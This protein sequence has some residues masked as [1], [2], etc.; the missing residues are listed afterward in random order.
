MHHS[1]ALLNYIQL[2][3]AWDDYIAS[4]KIDVK[5]NWTSTEGSMCGSLGK[6]TNQALLPNGASVADVVGTWTRQMGYPFIRVNTDGKTLKV[7]QG[8]I[9]ISPYQ[10]S[11]SQQL[12]TY[13]I[14]SH[15]KLFYINLYN[16]N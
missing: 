4:E 5:A 11:V 1:K 15:L 10:E 8:K 2:F 13:I 3:K 9:Q 7:Q 12:V 16:L 14:E 6:N